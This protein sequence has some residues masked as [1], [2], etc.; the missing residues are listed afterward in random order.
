MRETMVR[1]ISAIKNFICTQTV[2]RSVDEAGDGKQFKVL[3]EREDRLDYY[4][5]EAHYKVMKVNGET[6]HPEKKIVR[7]FLHLGNGF[8][9]NYLLKG[10]F[11]PEAKAVIQWDHQESI[12]GE[13]I[14]IFHYE[15]DKKYSILTISNEH[16]RIQEG[17]H[18]FVSVACDSG[19]IRRLQMVMEPVSIPMVNSSLF[20]KKVEEKETSGTLDIRYR[21]TSIGPK[22]FPLPQSSLALQRLGRAVT[23]SEST[24]HD[25]RKFEADARIVPPVE[26]GV[27]EG[28]RDSILPAA[29]GRS[30]EA[31]RER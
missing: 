1:Y 10:I 6:L 22:V 24:F 8:E 7:R 11:D 16:S 30:I 18:G 23:K 12:G 5:N 31:A 25:Y 15:V 4:S 26:A 21:P 27:Y 13:E 20:M 19:E 28:Q 2:R 14:C 29:F 9:F 17:H 3:E